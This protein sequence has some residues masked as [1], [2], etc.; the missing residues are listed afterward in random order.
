MST[1]RFTCSWW[2]T[3]GIETVYRIS[4]VSYKFL[5]W[6]S[7]VLSRALLIFV[8]T[9]WRADSWGCSYGNDQDHAQDQYLQIWRTDGTTVS[10]ILFSTV[11]VQASTSDCQERNWYYFILTLI[12][13]DRHEHYINYYQE[14]GHRM[15]LCVSSIIWARIAVRDYLP[16]TEAAVLQN[17]WTNL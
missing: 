6:F 3:T 1:C 11:S 9:A 17:S 5:P 13:I 2:R 10:L 8:T 14:D 12:V 7:W 16:D 15:R 4:K